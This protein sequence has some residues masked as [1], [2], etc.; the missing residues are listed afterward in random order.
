MAFYVCMCLWSGAM[1]LIEKRVTKKITI[2]QY[3]NL[4]FKHLYYTDLPIPNIPQE[5][6]TNLEEESSTNWEDNLPLSTS[7]DPDF[8]P[9]V[10]GGEPHKIGQKWLSDLTRD[11]N[12]T[13]EK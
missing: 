10:H 4:P 9:N 3:P 8:G 11:L 5:Y 1:I 2:I 13:K 12:L 7:H 6:A